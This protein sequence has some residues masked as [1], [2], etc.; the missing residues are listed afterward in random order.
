MLAGQPGDAGV[1]AGELLGQVAAGAGSGRV[2]EGVD[3]AVEVVAIGQQ[4]VPHRP[5]V[6]AE[7]LHPQLRVAR[8]DP[9]HIAQALAGEVERGGGGIRQPAGHQC[10][11]DLGH[12]GDE[13]DAA[14]VLLRRHFD[15]DRAEVEDEVVDRGGLLV[16]DRVVAGDDPGPPDEQVGAAG[17]RPAAFTTGERVRADVAGDVGAAG[18][19]VVEDGE[20]DAGDI[21]H[22]RARER[23]E[24]AGDDLGRDVGR[25]ADD[26]QLGLV[27]GGGGPAGPVVDG[28]A[29]VGRRGVGEHDLDPPVAEA[30]AD[31]G[32]EQSDADDAHRSD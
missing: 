18:A 25:H 32:S 28:D 16:G 2:G 12:V 6:R 17:Q 30:E 9:G 13:R 29:Q 23:R 8:R 10:G 14:V 21:R 27:G 22:D 24:F 4:D 11:D 31:A 26:D 5:R 3:E 20:L 19:Q 15:D 1:A 7:D